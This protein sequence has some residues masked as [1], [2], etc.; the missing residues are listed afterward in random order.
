MSDV[1]F[2]LDETSIGKLIIE[3]DDVEYNSFVIPTYQR[4]Y[5]WKKE[6]WNMLLTDIERYIDSNDNHDL[7]LGTIITLS[8]EQRK[9]GSIEVIRQVI[10]GQQRLTTIFILYISII[11]QLKNI[12]IDAIP[13]QQKRKKLKNTIES[14]ESICH[15]KRLR[16]ENDMLLPGGT[17]TMYQR[18]YHTVFALPI[19]ST[20]DKRSRYFLAYKFFAEALKKKLNKIAS[21]EEKFD[22]IFK[23]VFVVKRARIIWAS[24]T[25]LS[26][27]IQMFDVLNS[28][29]LPLS[30]TDII[31][32][33]YLAG[34]LEAA[35]INPNVSKED[36]VKHVNDLWIELKR[37]VKTG[38]SSND[39]KT[40]A[41]FRRYLRHT[42]MLHKGTAIIESRMPDEYKNWMRDAIRGISASPSVWNSN[43]LQDIFKQNA[44]IYGYIHNPKADLPIQN[45]FVF[46]ETMIKKSRQSS[47]SNERVIVEMLYDITNLGLIQINLMLLF[48]LATFAEGNY[49]QSEYDSRIKIF[50]QI[51]NQIW[52]FAIRRDVTDEPR[53]NAMDGISLR[54]INKIKEKLKEDK[55]IS[56]VDKLELIAHE[57]QNA[58]ELSTDV[59]ESKLKSEISY[60]SGPNV[61]LRYL[62]HILEKWEVFDNNI[63][64]RD[65]SSPFNG[66]EMVMIGG[67]PRLKWTIEHVLPQSM[68]GSVGTDV[69]D[70]D[71]ELIQATLDSRPWED[72]L[73]G[74]NSNLIQKSPDERA[75]VIHGIGNLTLM[76]HNSNL[77]DS[78]LT[79]KQHATKNN[80]PI[81]FNSSSPKFLNQ[82]ISFSTRSGKIMTLATTDQWTESEIENRENE[83]IRL[84]LILLV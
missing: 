78:R 33:T 40:D 84:L 79:H 38:V 73:H 15:P 20:V 23:I 57:V 81:G 69:D 7:F 4:R 37:V 70:E 51:V 16:H 34:M 17:E 31:R 80:N 19:G 8:D 56:T 6:Q 14:L 64:L 46:L 77:S 26:F 44:C 68:I 27:A 74:W 11:E 12:E 52:K 61:K 66:F 72:D 3:E 45:I 5:D 28:R 76:D 55:H 10:D 63:R 49:S 9:T 60:E 62:L 13:E 1:M 65:I 82:N 53:P 2:K 50:K 75:K 24:V 30:V 25:E 58:I 47:S 54:M 59:L 43:P 22:T 32:T 42:F 29:G 21:H 83:I 35:Q 39:D 18:L 67:Q 48:V 41:L 36:I 71:V